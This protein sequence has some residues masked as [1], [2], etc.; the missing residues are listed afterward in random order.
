[1]GSIHECAGRGFV[2]FCCV[3]VF[4]LFGSMDVVIPAIVEKILRALTAV[5]IVRDVQLFRARRKEKMAAHV[6]F[7]RK[8]L[9]GSRGF[10]CSKLFASVAATI[11]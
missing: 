7:I 10:D 6:F 3:C 4:M 11:T 9:P 1:M 8:I 2:V 5:K